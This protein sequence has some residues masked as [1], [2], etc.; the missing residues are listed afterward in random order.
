M[1][2][3]QDLDERC[4][5]EAV[6]S[7]LETL[8]STPM[9]G[10]RFLELAN[11]RMEVLVASVDLGQPRLS[12]RPATSSC[13]CQFEDAVPRNESAI[14]IHTTYSRRNRSP[15]TTVRVFTPGTA[16]TTD[17]QNADEGEDGDRSFSTRPR[18]VGYMPTMVDRVHLITQSSASFSI[19]SPWCR[20]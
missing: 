19:T 2:R 5:L 12:T 11:H 3:L 14:V 18:G 13:P 17:D 20:A 8:R 16:E 4:A 9:H 10:Q 6:A 7:A 15:I 1:Q